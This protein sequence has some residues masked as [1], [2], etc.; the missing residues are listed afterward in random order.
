LGVLGTPGSAGRAGE[1]GARGAEYPGS[2]REPRSLRLPSQP[3][4]AA[5]LCPALALSYC[6]AAMEPSRA[7]SGRARSQD[8]RLKGVPGPPPRAGRQGPGRGYVPKR[9]PGSPG[10]QGGKSPEVHSASSPPPTHLLPNYLSHPHF[11]P[12]PT[13][14]LPL[15]HHFSDLLFPSQP[16]SPR[17]QILQ[18][19]SAE[20]LQETPF[21][22]SPSLLSPT[23]RHFP[24][25]HQPPITAW[26]GKGRD[27]GLAS[28]RAGWGA[29][30]PHF[31]I[32]HWRGI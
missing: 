4:A 13:L 6:A 28:E 19:N 24:P 9:Q 23:L 27:S 30:C 16:S 26:L 5:A 20:C 32:C 1:T 11:F 29:S 21:P 14:T 8:R 3:P 15:L 12:F 22:S 18:G 31:P 7:G 25:H 2:A 17:T 10:S